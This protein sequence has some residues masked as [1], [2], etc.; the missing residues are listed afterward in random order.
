MKL[1]YY[2]ILYF[3]KAKCILHSS[4]CIQI[5][6][7]CVELVPNFVLCMAAWLLNRFPVSVACIIAPVK[8]QKRSLFSQ[9]PVVII[10]N[11]KQVSR[12]SRFVHCSLSKE[13]KAQFR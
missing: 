7:Q 13:R 10:F 11:T 2:N 8:R 6:H 4:L 5:V 9:F 12:S 3:L 1:R